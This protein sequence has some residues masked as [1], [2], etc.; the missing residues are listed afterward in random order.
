MKHAQYAW[1]I[2]LYMYGYFI[3]QLSWANIF[4]RDCRDP[5]EEIITKLE[6]ILKKINRYANKNGEIKR[7]LN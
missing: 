6:Y 3:Q 1:S 5:K 7:N 4:I 2:F